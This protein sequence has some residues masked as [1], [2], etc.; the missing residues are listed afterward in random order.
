MRAP[1]QVG[2]T[3]IGF[4]MTPMIDIVFLLLIFYLV[5]N[6]MQRD[7]QE[8]GVTPPSSAIGQP[9]DSDGRY[10][11]FNVFADGRIRVQGLDV[12]QAELVPLLAVENQKASGQLKVRIRGDRGVQYR[13][14]EPILLACAQTGVWDVVF[15]VTRPGAVPG[16]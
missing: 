2:R 8:R 11:V 16:N 3:P 10:V 13:H 9:Q 7:Q 6:T 12:P 14:V 1:T 15:A 5:S 4:N